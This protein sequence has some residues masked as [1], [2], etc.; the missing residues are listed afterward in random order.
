MDEGPTHR[1]FLS[2]NL[3]NYQALK[4]KQSILFL[5]KISPIY[6]TLLKHSI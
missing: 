5:S 3:F 4:V 1:L 6:F 2:T